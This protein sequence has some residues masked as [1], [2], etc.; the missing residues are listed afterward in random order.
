MVREKEKSA[1]IMMRNEA[2]HPHFFP[3][4]LETI[5]DMSAMGQNK[6][7][8]NPFRIFCQRDRLPREDRPDKDRPRVD[9]SA[10]GRLGVNAGRPSG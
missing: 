7:V 5:L 10:A 1:P 3:R 6:K 9:L 2:R 4:L 8:M